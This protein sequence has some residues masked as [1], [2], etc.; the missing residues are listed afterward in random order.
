MSIKDYKLYRKY[1]DK[2]KVKRFYFI[3]KREI[4][5]LKYQNSMERG[6]SLFDCNIKEYWYPFIWFWVI[7][8]R[9]YDKTDEKFIS[10]IILMLTILGITLSLLLK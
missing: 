5:S 3:E 1:F 2:S 7:L 9:W 4:D 8:V 6:Y 10:L